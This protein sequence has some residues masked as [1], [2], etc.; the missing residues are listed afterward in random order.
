MPTS[1]SFFLWRW[2]A[3]IAIGFSSIALA[4]PQAMSYT[5][6]VLALEIA[7]IEV[8]TDVDS[9]LSLQQV[10][11]GQ[12]GA[13]RSQADQQLKDLTYERSIWAKIHLRPSAKAEPGTMTIL[14]LN[15]PFLDSAVLYSPVLTA[16]GWSWQ[17]QRAGVRYPSNQTTLP[18]Q[19]PRFVLPAAASLQE[20]PEALRVVILQIPHRVQAM[21]DLRLLNGT[22]ALAETRRDSLGMGFALGAITLVGLLMGL[23]AWLYKN[24]LYLWYGAYTLAAGLFA[25]ANAGLGQNLLWPIEGDWPATAFLVMVLLS[26]ACQLQFSRLIFLTSGRNRWAS[27]LSK[28]LGAACVLLSLVYIAV[29][30]SYWTEL[31]FASVALIALTL[32]H[33]LVIVILGWRQR[34]AF[35]LVWLLIYLPLFL[36]LIYSFLNAAAMVK[37]YSFMFKMPIYAYAFEVIAMGIAIM[38]FTRDRQAQIERQKALDSTD[39][40]TGFSNA[41]SFQQALKQGWL[42]ARRTGSEISVVY[43]SLLGLPPTERT[44]KRVVRILRTVSQEGDTVARL[45]DGSMAL[46]LPGVTLDENLSARLSRIVALGMIPESND[47]VNPTLRFRICATSNRHYTGELSG[48]GADLR[49]FLANSARWE[50][51]TIRFLSMRRSYEK[52]VAAGDDTMGE[53]WDQALEAERASGRSI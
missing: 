11:D 33:V 3:G 53:F 2:F 41:D 37:T 20:R 17:M 49:R 45:D 44:L 31:Y 28:V 36:A 9:R 24:Q 46:L 7:N 10:L 30:S 47:Q 40:L 48:I 26:M 32:V 18:G 8:L 43:V 29:Q 23:L 42:D 51:K 27:Q 50:G 19:L 6:P 14:E 25:A 1:A 13:F 15:K 12:A 52:R 4:Q 38:W 35:A 39:P 16:Q 21:I 5:N 22:Q 34:G